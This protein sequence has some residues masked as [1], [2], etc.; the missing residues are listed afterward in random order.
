MALHPRATLRYP[1]IYGP[2]QVL[3]FEWCLVRRA[4]D[5]RPF[6]VLPDGGLRLITRG[7]SENTAQA[8]LCAVD[9]PMEAGG[10]IY[11]C[12]DERQLALR[13]VAEV[14]AKTFCHQLEIVSLPASLAV[15][16]WPMIIADPQGHDR[17]CSVVC[18]A[19]Q[20]A[21]IRHRKAARRFLR[22][23][24]GGSAIVGLAAVHPTA[25]RAVWT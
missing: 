23:C 11:N 4:L 24:G 10:Q 9:R 1:I 18:R 19:P 7:Y 2:H 16:S 20:F 6:V 8:V 15:P 25:A 13:Q 21:G 12:G 14:V 3:P 22:L 17:Y 5:R